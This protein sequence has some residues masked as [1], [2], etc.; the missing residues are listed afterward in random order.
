[1]I[2][3]IAVKHALTIGENEEEFMGAAID[4][5]DEGVLWVVADPD[6]I[7]IDARWWQV[8]EPYEFWGQKGA[9]SFTEYEIHSCTWNGFDVLNEEEVFQKKELGYV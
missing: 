8:K 1:M 4:D 9:E 6:D 3:Q 5:Y 7:E 2:I